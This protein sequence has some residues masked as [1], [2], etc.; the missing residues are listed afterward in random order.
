MV[1][2]IP[3]TELSLHDVKVKFDLTPAEDDEFFREWQDE[4]PELTDT[5]RQS[6]EQ[7]KA[8]MLYLEQ[9]PMVED[10]VKMVVLR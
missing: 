2:T 3:V 7:V 4:L 6:L 1:K 8:H 9:Y 10:I 5:E